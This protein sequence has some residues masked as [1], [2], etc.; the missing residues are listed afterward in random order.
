MK[1]S[2]F[3]ALRYLV[4]KKNRNIINIMSWISVSGI[5]VGTVALVIV[6]SVMNG[7]NSLINTFFSSF[8][9]DLKITAVN[10]KWFDPEKLD[11][12]K[13]KSLP[14][15]IHYAEIIEEVA[16]L[17]YGDRQYF[18]TVKG[19]S[20]NFSDYTSIDSLITDGNYIIEEQGIYY[21]V[22][23]Q[24]IA[25]T[26]GIGLT[27]TDP[28][29]I[30]VPKKGRQVILNPSRAVN[31]NYIY[32]SGIF[33]V[34]EEIDSKYI[35]VPFTYA[36]DLFESGNQVSSIELDI[37]NDMNIRKIQNE[38]IKIAGE[39]FEV[40]NKYQQHDLINKT[41]RTEKWFTYFILIFILL[42]A[43]FSILSSLSMLIID[44]TEDI[45]ILQSM[46]ATANTIRK[47]FL[48]EGW[49]ISLT[50]ALTGSLIG[51]MICWLQIKFGF[52]KLPGEG[53]FVISA[54]PVKII[55]SEIL[56]INGIVLLTGFLASWYPVRFINWQK[57]Y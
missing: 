34:I 15:V 23:G 54:Y 50:G 7:F 46:G 31:Y 28:I 51:L 11:V 52:I 25:G 5:I 24:G 9:P 20:E 16:M 43:S 13:L 32:P 57:L 49:L 21:A 47:I 2:L 41:L 10:G 29:R 22:V 12:D 14:G 44:K 3:I 37:A 38:I 17:K 4:S 18:A 53:S 36:A 39:E 45:R 48:Y 42:I 56:M 40:K 33:S 1:L 6:L 8:D 27:F 19:V 30:Y 26:L 55:F 35:L